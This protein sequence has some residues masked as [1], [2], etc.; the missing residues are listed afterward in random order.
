MKK[1][2][3]LGLLLAISLATMGQAAGPWYIVSDPAVIPPGDT[4]TSITCL[5][6][7]GSAT[8]VATPLAVWKAQSGP[9][10]VIDTSV[11]P[12]GQQALTVWYHSSVTLQDSPK[13]PFVF[14]LNAPTGLRVTQ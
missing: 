3:L 6:Q 1:L 5:Y 13:V 9:G 14:G 4:A 8:P 2:L 10:C 7:I 11:F 12:P